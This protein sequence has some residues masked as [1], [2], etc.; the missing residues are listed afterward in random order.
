MARISTYSQDPNLEGA[1]RIVG[2]DASNG[3]ATVN[4]SLNSLG[5]FFT[6]S[7]IADATRLAYRFNHVI[8]GAP[9]NENIIPQG[10]YFNFS[11][12][13]SAFSTLTSVTVAATDVSGL[14]VGIL[15]DVIQ[16]GRI[17]II[18][19]R[20]EAATTRAQG[21][22]EVND[23]VALE[24]NAG[25]EVV[26]YRF[27]LSTTNIP[28]AQIGSI[29]SGVGGDES[30][31]LIPLS[32]VSASDTPGGVEFAFRNFVVQDT[33]VTI[34]ADGTADSLTFIGGDGID[35]TGI[36]QVGSGSITVTHGNTG[37]AGGA[38]TLSMDNMVLASLTIDEFGHISD[39][40]FGQG[41][42]TPVTPTR[43]PSYSFSGGSSVPG[44]GGTHTHNI[45][46]G[47]FTLSGETYSLSDQSNNGITISGSTVT[48]PSTINSGSYTVRA[49]GNF[50]QDDLSTNMGSFDET[51]AVNIF[52][53]Y[54]FGTTASTDAGIAN[55]LA[56]RGTNEIP[57]SGGSHTFTGTANGDHVYL[58]LSDTIFTTTP[59][60]VLNNFPVEA[61]DHTSLT[62]GYTTYI[63]TSS[64]GTITIRIN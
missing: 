28:S 31:I 6:K 20:S 50:V 53:P 32:P 9:T 38:Q 42:T 18:T 16:S 3:N 5:D 13:G 2:S 29:Q 56:T 43:T 4:F 57:A 51:H 35:L 1:D 52:V 37:T 55:T 54:Y 39:A 63:F 19:T 59:T 8:G 41:G 48:I 61:I 64:G 47:G 62:T 58:N 34:D 49:T 23:F 27:D 24:N 33:G 44:D 11:E 15:E 60:F 21:Y 30:F 26:G 36:D 17:K 25:T 7:G 40:T 10:I 14:N 22:F 12:T 46:A 45:S